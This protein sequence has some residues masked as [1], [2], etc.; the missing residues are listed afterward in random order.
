MRKFSSEEAL[1][2]FRR[3]SGALGFRGLEFLTGL[4]FIGFI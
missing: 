2:T 4:G 1:R 3:I